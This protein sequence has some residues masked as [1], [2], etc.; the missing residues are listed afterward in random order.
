LLGEKYNV[1]LPITNAVYSILYEK[2]EPLKVFNNL[3]G[4]STRKEF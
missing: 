1:D 2:K 3:F 4:R